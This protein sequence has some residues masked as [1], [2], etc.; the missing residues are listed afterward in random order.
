LTYYYVHVYVYAWSTVFFTATG[1]VIPARSR[2]HCS[3]LIAFQAI[4]FLAV[5]LHVFHRSCHPFLLHPPDIYLVFGQRAQLAFGLPSLEGSQLEQFTVP[6][7][8]AHTRKALDSCPLVGSVR[9]PLLLPMH[10]QDRR[11]D[12]TSWISVRVAP[13]CAIYIVPCCPSPLQLASKDRSEL[14]EPPD[15]HCHPPPR[16]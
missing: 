11:P 3:L 1:F 16:S 14:F 15:L 7:Q 5:S 2:R 10:A 4:Q 8:S 6:A 13:H 9:L 12:D